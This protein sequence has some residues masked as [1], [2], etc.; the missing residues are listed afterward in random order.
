MESRDT[1]EFA[2]RETTTYIHTEIFNNEVGYRLFISNT[3]L[4]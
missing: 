2:H 4:R 1:G 3:V